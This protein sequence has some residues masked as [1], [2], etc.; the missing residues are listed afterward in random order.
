MRS[1]KG[2]AAAVVLL[3]LCSAAAG[4][5]EAAPGKA[6]PT[7]DPKATSII[8]QMCNCFKAA[9]GLSV[10]ASY[11]LT[12]TAGG[13]SNEATST[14]RMAARR[15]NLLC[16]SWAQSSA[17]AEPM[18]CT[19]VCDGKNLYVSIPL[20]KQY[21][22]S[23]APADF[24]ALF[25]SKDA[26]P[27][28]SSV[29]LFLDSLLDNDPYESIMGAVISARYVGAEAVEGGRCH[30]LKLAREDEDVDLWVAAGEKPLPLKAIL[31][32]SK[33]LRRMAGAPADVQRKLTIRFENWAINP[34][35]PA[36][37]FQFVPPG[38]SRKVASLIEPD[39]PATIPAGEPAPDFELALLGGGQMTL[40]Q[41]KGKEIVVLDFWASWCPPCRRSMP[42]IES[43]AAAFKDKGVVLYAINQ[44]EDAATIRKFLTAQ[45]LNVTVA[46]DKDRAVGA[47]YGAS[48]IPLTVIV[49]KDGIIQ[50]VHGGI[51]AGLRESLT[52]ELDA[53][54]AEKRLTGEKRE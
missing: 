46:L 5:P 18:T 2:L 41:H 45:K 33:S 23:K 53:L 51:R 54:T 20:L 1:R 50:A 10:D 42:I 34:D 44:G 29:P 11:T 9:N 22:A 19:L 3:A 21:T 39:E 14:V 17:Q 15:P 43:V 4:Q 27:L 13:Q 32:P 49:G 52:G 26:I 7:L 30:H 36:E 47:Q 12:R 40:S 48:A 31:D 37:R 28:I 6:A 8:R 38:G 24:G 25:S 16:V 35:L